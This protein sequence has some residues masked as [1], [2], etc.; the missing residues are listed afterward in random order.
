MPLSFSELSGRYNELW[1]ETSAL[2]EAWAR[3]NG[4]SYHEL[5]V[6]LSI[7]QARGPCTQKTICA[8]W[9]VPKQTVHSVLQGFLARGLVRLCPAPGD[10]RNKQIECTPQGRAFLR[11]LHRSWMRTRPPCGGGWARS[12]AKPFWPALRFTTAFSERSVRLEVG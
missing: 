10:R 7:A 2:Y 8:Q 6:V 3:Q 1:R 9:A 12:K 5:L 11:A 4:L